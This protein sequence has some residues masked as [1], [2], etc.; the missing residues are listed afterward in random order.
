MKFLS[1]NYVSNESDAGGYAL[2]TLDDA[3]VKTILER[4][5]LHQM[6][7]SKDKELVT[8]EF[9]GAEAEFFDCYVGQYIEET[10]TE[11][12]VTGLDEGC[13]IR[14][15][16][17]FELPDG[18]RIRTDCDR[19]VIREDGITWS[20]S[21]HYGNGDFETREL[22]FDEMITS[23]FIERVAPALKKET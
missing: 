3:V 1:K 10:L 14:V 17:S 19:M 13:L 6:V 2:I 9:W 18:V 20:A 8:L 11:E 4:K 15:A 16:D 12:E 5:E 22:S 23:V 21:C 7:K